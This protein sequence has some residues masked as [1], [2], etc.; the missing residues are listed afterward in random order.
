M[1]MHAERALELQ[2]AIDERDLEEGREPRSLTK[3][4][5]DL[6]ESKRPPSLRNSPLASPRASIGI[7]ASLGNAKKCFQ[8]KNLSLTIP[9]SDQCVV[10]DLSFKLGADSSLLIMGPSGI[11]KSSLLRAISGLWQAR[12]GNISLPSE[13][14]MFLPQMPYIPEIPLKSNTLEA[15]FLFP[16]VYE[17]IEEEELQEVM[18]CVNLTHLLGEEGVFT[19]EEWGNFLSGGEKQRLAMG[20]L[21]IAKPEI[22][23][24]DEAT[25]ALDHENERRVYKQLQACGTSYVSVGHKKSLEEFHTHILEIKPNGKWE[26]RAKHISA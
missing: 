6:N 14:I 21:L 25:S 17:S 20:R 15:Q 12:A 2:D 26:F 1:S 3:K 4:D 10:K 9:G 11:G 18:Q 19:T 22:A 24:M 8:I 16:R 23:F 7:R 13:D 5:D